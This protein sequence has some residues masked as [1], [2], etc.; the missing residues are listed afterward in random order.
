MEN[1]QTLSGQLLSDYLVTQANSGFGTKDETIFMTAVLTSEQYADFKN[2]AEHLDDEG[3]AI[4]META[5]S[6]SGQR[7][8]QFLEAGAASQDSAS[9][10][11]SMF[12]SLS[13]ATR[14]Q[15]LNTSSKLEGEN[16][17]NFVQASVKAQAELG[18]FLE[19][20]NELIAEIEY[21]PTGN[22][23]YQESTLQMFLSLSGDADSEDLQGFI[24]LLGKFDT[25]PGTTG[26]E[27]YY[28]MTKSINSN[29]SC[30]IRVAYQSGMEQNDINR[31]GNQALASGEERFQGYFRDE[32][33]SC[34]KH[35]AVCYGL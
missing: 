9:D 7:R 25:D 33:F 19:I 18:N 6:L 4:L 22:V 23:E 17:A 29:R 2:T 10:F 3:L 24:S 21:L 16:L 15:Y 35:Q 5:D 12:N 20:T 32:Q 11:L 31:L 8:S 30:F 28:D 14:S 13:T 26:I 27:G 34:R 1:A